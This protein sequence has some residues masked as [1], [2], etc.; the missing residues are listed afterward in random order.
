MDLLH[1]Q[2]AIKAAWILGLPIPGSTNIPDPGPATG[3]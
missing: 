1:A 3:T 2:K